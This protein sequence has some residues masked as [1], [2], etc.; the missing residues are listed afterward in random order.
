[1]F[2]TKNFLVYNSSLNFFFSLISRFW[3]N[4]IKNPNFIFDVNKTP[5]EDACLSVIAQT[6]M[7]SCS[8]MVPMLNYNSTSHKLLFVKD[9]L[10]NIEMV[11]K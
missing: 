1:M 4:Y 3:V 9:T 2:T 11:S 6:L 5:T 8:T 7:E 10:K